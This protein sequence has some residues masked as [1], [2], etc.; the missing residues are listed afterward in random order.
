MSKE[1][2]KSKL[3]EKKLNYFIEDGV[4]YITLESS[5]IKK[6]LT[7][8]QESQTNMVKQK[9]TVGTIISLYQ[10]ENRQLKEK[11]MQLEEKIDKL[12]D[13]KE[14]MLKAER[15]KIEEIYNSKDEQLKNILELINAKM[16]M[17]YSAN[18][19]HEVEHYVPLKD[20]EDYIVDQKLIELRTYLKSLDL[21]SSQRKIIKKRFLNVYDNDVRIIQQN[22]QL[23]LDFSKYD[24]T[25]LLAY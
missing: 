1:M 7:I 13:D 3:R 22:G 17:D 5:E 10:K 25:D 21:R 24:Y 16:K 11:I 18:T 23:Y 2:V 6:D 19:I 14:E 4:T 12:I 15:D 20:E 8:V 9:T